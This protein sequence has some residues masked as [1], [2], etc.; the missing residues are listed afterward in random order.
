MT[1][2]CRDAHRARARVARQPDLASGKPICKLFLI[3]V[4]LTPLVDQ[5]TPLQG[6][7]ILPTYIPA[8]ACPSLLSINSCLCIVLTAA[9]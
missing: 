3:S 5:Y 4:S 2:S 1:S 7:W 6:N 9:V 8:S